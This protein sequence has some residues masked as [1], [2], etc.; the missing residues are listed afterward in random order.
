M[1]ME[2]S[3]E[4]A[5]KTH[6]EHA[7]TTGQSTTK[8]RQRK[9]LP[10]PKCRTPRAAIRRF[11][12]LVTKFTREVS[13]GRE[14]LTAECEMVRQAAA[15][16]LRAEQLQAGIVAGAEIDPDELIRLSSEGRRVLRSIRAGAKPEASPSPSPWS[17]LRNQPQTRVGLADE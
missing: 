6:S 9:R 1:S 3:T 10:A 13:D 7:V 11:N 15:I 4:M 5:G 12:F 14:L 17:A 8:R 16:M 2:P